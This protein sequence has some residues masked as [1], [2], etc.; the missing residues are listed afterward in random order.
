MDRRIGVTAVELVDAAVQSHARGRSR[1]VDN[2]AADD[3]V[4]DAE[5]V[6]WVFPIACVEEPGASVGRRNSQRD[7]DA[8]VSQHGESQSVGGLL[9]HV[10]HQV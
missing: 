10:L 5:S 4:F 9:G 6:L 7:P 8:I 1:S 2:G 3:G